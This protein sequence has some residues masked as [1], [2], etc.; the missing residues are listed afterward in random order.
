[1]PVSFWAIFLVGLIALLTVMVIGVAVAVGYNAWRGQ[2]WT[3]WGGLIGLVLVAG[4]SWT[5][6][7]WA[8]FA[9]IP[10]AVAAGLLWLPGVKR[11]CAA[12]APTRSGPANPPVDPSPVLYGPH[13]PSGG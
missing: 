13:R 7:P 8:I 4:L 6:H 9:V 12:V 10:Y 5:L 1:A 2:G 3:R 11:H